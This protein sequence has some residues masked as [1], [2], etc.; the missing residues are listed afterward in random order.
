ML[1]IIRLVEQLRGETLKFRPEAEYILD[2][3]HLG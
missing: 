1:K 3:T 2:L